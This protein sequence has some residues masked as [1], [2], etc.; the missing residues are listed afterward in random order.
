MEF[1]QMIFGKRLILQ[2]YNYIYLLKLLPKNQSV[3]IWS[4][5]CQML[6]INIIASC[7]QVYRKI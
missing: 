3:K 1:E 4:N 7:V 2:T 5:K 6:M